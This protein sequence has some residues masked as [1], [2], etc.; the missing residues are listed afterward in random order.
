MSQNG[1]IPES[2]FTG[3]FNELISLPFLIVLVISTIICFRDFRADGI[4]NGFF[5]LLEF[6][7][8]KGILTALIFFTIQTD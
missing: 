2:V 4:R 1:L 7:T 3:T 6:L 5:P 8:G